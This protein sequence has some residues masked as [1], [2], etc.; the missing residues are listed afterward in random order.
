MWYGRLATTSYGGSTR[1]TRSWSSASP[2][3]SRSVRLVREPLAQERREAAIELDRGDRR[4]GGQEARRSGSRGPARSRGSGGRAR[5]RPRPGSRRARPDRP[6][7]SATGCDA[8]ADRPPAGSPG[9]SP[10]RPAVARSA[11]IRRGPDGQG[12]RRPGVE[13]E[14][15]PLARREPPRT[16]RADHRPVVRAQRGSRHDQRQA[17]RLGLPGEACPQDA[18]RG[19]PA[20]HHDR[21]GAARLGGP[22]RLGHE[23][24]DDRV[25]EAP[26]ELGDDVV[27]ERLLGVGREPGVGAGLGDDPAGRGLEAGEAQ[28]VANRPARPAGRPGRAWS[29]PRPR[30]RSPARPGSRARAAARPCRTPRRR[31]RRGSSRAADRPGGRASRR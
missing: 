1:W 25:L 8:P 21:A 11:L 3:M 2:S 9:R 13:V 18:V 17:E 10:G 23:D 12:Q 22:D 27:G 28:V 26:G 20:A 14:A 29:P 16:G 31:R 7:S 24:V 6:G 4:A 5:D 30:G 19:D 15:G